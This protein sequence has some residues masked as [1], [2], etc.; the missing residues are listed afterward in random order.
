MS[1]LLQESLEQGSVSEFSELCRESLQNAF[2]KTIL[3]EENAEYWIT[4]KTGKHIGLDKN[5]KAIT[6]AGGNIKK[7]TSFSKANVK[8]IEEDLEIE[9]DASDIAEFFIREVLE[10]EIKEFC[11]DLDNREEVYQELEAR[12]VDKEI[13]QN[14]LALYPL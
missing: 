13:L 3:G 2:N 5:K 10:D 6:T 8:P 4:T 1:Q 11:Q 7:G 9:L 14:F 12:D